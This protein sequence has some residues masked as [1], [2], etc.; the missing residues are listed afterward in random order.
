[1][2]KLPLKS[3]EIIRRLLHI[4]F[5][6]DHVTGSHVIL[7]HAPTGRR[8]VVPYHAGDLPKGTARAILR[9]AKISTQE[10]F[11]ENSF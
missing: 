6:K 10:F 2:P 7:Y 1:M 8:A 4:G 3:R 11:D 9:E 5:I